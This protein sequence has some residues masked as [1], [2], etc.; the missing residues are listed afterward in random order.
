[1]QIDNAGSITKA[2]QEIMASGPKNYSSL[3]NY[4]YIADQAMVYALD[5]DPKNIALL[6]LNFNYA[7]QYNDP[8]EDLIAAV[9]NA[10]NF[11][12]GSSALGLWSLVL[13]L[14]PISLRRAL[15]RS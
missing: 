13:L 12:G 3:S 2:V 5:E 10:L 15:K 11:K 1:L 9:K 8:Q 6:D 7:P 14:I 4:A